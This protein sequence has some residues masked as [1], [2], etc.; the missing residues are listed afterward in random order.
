[1]VI[2]TGSI[3]ARRDTFDELLR[4]SL[5]HVAR[6]RAEPGCLEHGVTVDANDGLRLVFFERWADRDALLVHFRLPASREFVAQVAR[7]A[8]HPPAIAAYE[9]TEVPLR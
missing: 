2:V 1:M 4:L 6:S 5:E 7:L 3:Q 8:A 9:A